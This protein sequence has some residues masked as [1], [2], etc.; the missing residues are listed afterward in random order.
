MSVN[1]AGF[2]QKLDDLAQFFLFL[3][4]AGD[5]LEGDVVGLGSVRRARLLP[6]LAMP[7][8]AAR[9]RAHDEV[10]KQGHEADEDENGQQFHPPRRTRR[11]LG[12]DVETILRGAD[13][14]AQHLRIDGVDI[15]I[16]LFLAGD[17]AGDVVAGAELA[18]GYL[19]VPGTGDEGGLSDDDVRDR[20]ALFL[21]GQLHALIV[22]EVSLDPLSS[23]E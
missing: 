17:G 11:Q 9:L 10:V 13:L 12:G 2:F 19:A 18:L 23:D 22:L 16:E 5:I 14:A 15:C 6:K 1:L 3:V 7:L 8:A 20:L 4:R 21:A